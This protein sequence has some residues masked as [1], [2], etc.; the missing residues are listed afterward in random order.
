MSRGSVVFELGSDS[1]GAF[2]S[3]QAVA[4]GC[5]APASK[6]V[7]CPV[8]TAPDSVLLAGLEGEDALSVAGFPETTSIVLLGNEGKD[9]L[10]GSENEDV[11]VD[12]A[13]NDVVNA[14]SRDDAVPNNEGTDVLHA[15]AG[16]DLFISNSICEGDLLDGGPD[17][18]NANWANFGSS[19]SID[20]AAKKAG[21]G[22][23]GQAPACGGNPLS[24]LE[25]IE[26]IEGTNLGDAL[27]G[28]AGP[29]QL[30]GRKGPDSY[31]AAA[32]D[33]S[34]LANSGDQDSAISCGEGFDTAQVDHPQYGDPVP[35]ECEAVY[36]R[37]PNSFR[38]PDTPPDPSPEEP[39]PEPAVEPSPPPKQGPGRSPRPRDLTPPQTRILGA[40]PRLI[41]TTRRVR[42]V[43]F[44]FAA[45]EQGATFRCR[46]DRGRFQPC[47]SPRVYRLRRG[48]HRV[49]IFAIDGAGNRDRSPA[50]FAFRIRR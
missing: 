33:D 3:A 34:I 11:L 44:R 30:L 9:T 22:G 1:E 21:L 19:I 42:R 10:T 24:T 16:E 14:G 35:S 15:G 5:D 29:N 26:D 4:G 40:P 28:D 7:S 23:A 37:N 2:D 39:A 8:S 27:I 18:D 48:F 6:K 17:R 25:G 43:V 36:E 50:S 31:F 45:S 13:D 46:L 20:M 12:G 32:G 47:R 49:R 38:P 41:K